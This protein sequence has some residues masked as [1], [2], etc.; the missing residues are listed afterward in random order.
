MAW[1]DVNVRVD[2]LDDDVENGTSTGTREFYVRSDALITSNDSFLAADDGTTAIPAATAAYSASRPY[3][4]VKSRRVKRLDGFTATV[5]VSYADPT[6]GQF[7]TD[8]DLLLA[9]ARISIATDHQMEEYVKD[10]GDPPFH[11]RTPSGEPYDRGPERLMGIKVYTIRKFVTSAV[12]A[13]IEN[14]ELMLN[15]GAKTIRGRS[16][17]ALTLFLESVNAEDVEGATGVEEV[18][19]VIKARPD[20]WKDV[21]PNYGWT[22]LVDGGRKRITEKNH[23]G[24]NVAITRPW[25]LNE[26]GTKKATADA[27]PSETIY[28]P[29]FQSAWASVPLT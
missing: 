6:R 21:T 17:E 12:R 4:R 3:C 18:T 19:L 11:V 25:P 7:V 10:C 5:T 24:V 14:S 22:E 26:D 15:T 16:W 27:T 13:T 28:F 2:D 1:T 9:P 20:G 8:A 23:E 29:Y